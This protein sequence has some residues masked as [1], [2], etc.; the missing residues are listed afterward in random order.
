MATF[1]FRNKK[2]FYHDEG[3]GDPVIL[4]HG[5]A[6]DGN[7]WNKQLKYLKEN[8]RVIVP[9]L[10]DSGATE[11]VENVISIEDYADV[12]KALAEEVILKKENSS[13]NFCMIGHS[14]GGYITLAFAEKYA[15]V[16]NSF[17]LFH[18]SA[19]SDSD[20]KIAMRRKGIEFIRK[21]GTEPFVKTSVPNL[22]S[23][24]TKRENPQLIQ[25]LIEIAKSI[26]PEALINYYKAMI[27]RPDRT[28]VLKSFRKPVL[29]IAGKLDTA[30]PLNL[31]LEQFSMPSISHVHILQHSGHMGMWEEEELSNTF[32]HNFLKDVKISEL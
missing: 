17:G 29:L 31:S 32:L 20:E 16:L 23:E 26:S 6:E 21:N 10:P 5:F 28:S 27:D 2:I 18:S 1:Q 25:E 24:E 15:E 19:Y 3:E 8:F 13:T 9:D 30:V 12:L 22:F 11:F 4:V 7:V 14:M